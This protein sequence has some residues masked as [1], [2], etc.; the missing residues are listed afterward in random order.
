MVEG[1]DADESNGADGEG[2][3]QFTQVSGEGSGDEGTPTEPRESEGGQTQADEA[4]GGTMVE[5]ERTEGHPDAGEDDEDA[6]GGIEP[7]G[8]RETAPMSEY[9]GRQ[10]GVG[11]LVA[12]VGLLVAFGV[13]IA[14][15]L[16]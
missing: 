1:E 10:V 2:G 16:V 8:P 5:D 6:H 13:P 9:T 7:V 3:V 12:L 4:G 11:V 14:F 15:A